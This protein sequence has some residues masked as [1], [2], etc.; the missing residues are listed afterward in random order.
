[1]PAITSSDGATKRFADLL[2]GIEAEPEGP[3]RR[4]SIYF[5]VASSKHEA[6][7]DFSQ[8]LAAIG[9]ERLAIAFPDGDVPGVVGDP[10]VR[11]A[12]RSYVA[13]AGTVTPIGAIL[14]AR[15]AQEASR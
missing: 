1:M 4:W 14:R 15:I 11:A 12:A 3:R 9:P 13:P 6:P 5:A 10:L 8:L 2:V 7:V